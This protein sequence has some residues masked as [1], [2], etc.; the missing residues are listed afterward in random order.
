[1]SA[2]ET[3]LTLLQEIRDLLERQEAREI[4]FLM[5][6]RQRWEQED[7]CFQEQ[8]LRWDEHAKQNERA[9]QFN[10]SFVESEKPEAEK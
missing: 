7:R 6:L 5:D 10:Q 3:S 8:L 1:M 9:F 2:Q 4:A